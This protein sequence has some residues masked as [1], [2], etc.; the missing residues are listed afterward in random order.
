LDWTKPAMVKIMQI[1]SANSTRLHLQQNLSGTGLR[2]R[3][4]FDPQIAGGVNDDRSI[5]RVHGVSPLCNW[6][7]DT[8]NIITPTKEFR[9]DP[10][11]I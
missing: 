5:W 2:H 6:A 1:R 9:H 10:A 3:V 4:V 7:Y 11:N 8:G